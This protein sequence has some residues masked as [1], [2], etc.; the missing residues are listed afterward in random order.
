MDQMTKL[1]L[2]W[3]VSQG[4]YRLQH[5]PAGPT[6]ATGHESTSIKQVGEAQRFYDCM[7]IPG[8]Y[9]RLAEQEHGEAGALAFVGRFG[10]LRGSRQSFVEDVV[11]HI[12]SLRGLI[13]AKDRGD[14]EAL[15]SWAATNKGKLKLQAHLDGS[16]PAM[17][18]HPVT[19]LDAIYVQFF[20]DL[21]GGELQRCAN[22]VC[23]TDQQ[24]FRRGRGTTHRADAIYCSPTCQKT[25]AYAKLK[26]RTK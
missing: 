15:R 11:S 2:D 21:G 22:P 17:F 14:W 4:G 3:P 6:I 10:L 24:W 9:R 19:L 13:R 12:N 25:H 8:L 1:S 26:E 23:D 18:F 5:N 20:D 16:P 7:K